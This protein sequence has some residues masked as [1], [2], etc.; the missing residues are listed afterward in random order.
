MLTQNEGFKKYYTPSHF[1]AYLV[2]FLP[3]DIWSFCI[4]LTLFFF[5]IMGFKV[6]H[7][8]ALC[9]VGSTVVSKYQKPKVLPI[10]VSFF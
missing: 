4:T 3:N 5:L 2:N 1:T 9:L 7:I 8:N 6:F 10:P